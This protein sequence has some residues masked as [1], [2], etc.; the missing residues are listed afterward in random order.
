M[1][2]TFFIQRLETNFYSR[3]AIVRYSNLKV[4]FASGYDLLRRV[5]N[6]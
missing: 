5:Q 4:F 3:I 6:A 2:I 1:L